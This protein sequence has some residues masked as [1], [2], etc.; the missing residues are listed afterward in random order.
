MRRVVEEF[1][2]MPITQSELDFAAE[3]YENHAVVPYFNKAKWQ[4][5]IDEYGGYLPLEID[6][7][8]EG[9][10][11]LPGDPIMRLS[12]PSEIVA[13]FEPYVHR[14]FYESMVA[15]T[16]HEISREFSGRFIEV[17]KRGTPTEHMHLLAA[18]AMLL[19]GNIQYTSNDA[20]AVVHEQLKDVGTLGHRYVQSISIRET[21][22]EKDA[23]EK[24]ILETESVSLLIDLVDS[25][26]GISTAMELKERYRESGKKIWIR[27]D[28]GDI[29]GQTVFTLQEYA[30]KRIS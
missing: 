9:T 11:V 20:A 7:V 12:G 13:S 23:F 16:A 19:G 14:A 10:A 28:S 2:A 15:T 27:L 4:H 26:Q 22:T 25:Y 21:M 18:R 17:G 24:A 6:C 8:P 29:Q 30:K 3:F 5:I 1:A